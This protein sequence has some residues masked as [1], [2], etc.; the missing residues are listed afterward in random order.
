MNVTCSHVVHRLFILFLSPNSQNQSL[1]PNP[2]NL[3]LLQIELSGLLSVHLF[4]K[5]KKVYHSELGNSC[6]HTLLLNGRVF[7][8]N[9]LEVF[10]RV[11]RQR[12]IPPSDSSLSMP[13]KICL[14]YCE[15]L[16]GTPLSEALLLSPCSN[17]KSYSKRMLCACQV[18]LIPY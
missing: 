18:V 14:L 11:C 2:T 5:K 4:P 1:S 13:K 12:V 9:T 3:K 17:H 7:E 16:Y 6:V 15:R 8:F 10:P